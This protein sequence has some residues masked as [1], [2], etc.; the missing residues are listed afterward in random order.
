MPLPSDD[1]FDDTSDDT[2]SEN[3]M[4]GD[5]QRMEQD[6]AKDTRKTYQ[7]KGK[8]PSGMNPDGLC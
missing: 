8:R 6:S 7:I 5:G 1:I 3:I 2:F 4:K